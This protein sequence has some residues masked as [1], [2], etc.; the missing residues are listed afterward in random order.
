MATN[1]NKIPKYEI[2]KEF[3]SVI[4]VVPCRQVD[5]HDGT[6]S[7]FLLVIFK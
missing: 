6:I 5:R 2:S 7:L 3:I 1:V 4:H